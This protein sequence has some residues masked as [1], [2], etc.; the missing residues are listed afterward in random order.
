M[1]SNTTRNLSLS[2]LL[3]NLEVLPQVGSPMSPGFLQTWITS[4]ASPPFNVKVHSFVV[5][6]EPSPPSNTQCRN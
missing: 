6:E 2:L 1:V 3:L 4:V 5:S